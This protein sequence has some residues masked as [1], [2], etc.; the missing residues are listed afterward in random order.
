MGSRLLRA[1]ASCRADIWAMGTD[2]QNRE[3]SVLYSP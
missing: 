2:A 1:I 3:R